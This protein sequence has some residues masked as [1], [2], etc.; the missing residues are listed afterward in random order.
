MFVKIVKILCQWH[1]DYEF[2]R[3]CKLFCCTNHW[4]IWRGKSYQLLIAL[5]NIY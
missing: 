5:V 4:I 1:V 2:K 3:L